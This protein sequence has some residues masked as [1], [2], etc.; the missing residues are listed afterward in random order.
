MM[1]WDDFISLCR[2][3]LNTT[4]PPINDRL[5]QMKTWPLAC[6]ESELFNHPFQVRFTGNGFHFIMLLMKIF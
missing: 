1:S 6:F 5:Y 2:S 3:V 4:G